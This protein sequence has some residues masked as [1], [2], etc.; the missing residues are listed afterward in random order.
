LDKL[1]LKKRKNL[2]L[3]V[4][5][6]ALALSHLQLSSKKRSLKKNPSVLQKNFVFLGACTYGAAQRFASKKR[7]FFD[8]LRF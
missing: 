6:F 1:N 7:R 5:V 4:G 2:F 8:N 3:L